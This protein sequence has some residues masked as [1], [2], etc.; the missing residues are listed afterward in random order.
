MDG[1][2]GNLYNSDDTSGIGLDDILNIRSSIF[3]QDI[4]EQD[5]SGYSDINICSG[6]QK[7]HTEN[8]QKEK[9][10]YNLDLIKPCN[11]DAKHYYDIS[12]FSS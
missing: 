12:A 1:F 10:G 9:V 11:K 2:S 5:T 4:P 6:N 3:V 7:D 8:D